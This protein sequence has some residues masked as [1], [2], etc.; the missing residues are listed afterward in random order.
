MNENTVSYCI[1]RFN[2]NSIDPSKGG[3]Y[4]PELTVDDLPT[5][6]DIG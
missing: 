2:Y 3:E 4:N 5:I 6:F 1:S